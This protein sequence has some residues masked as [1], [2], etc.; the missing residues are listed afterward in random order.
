MGGAVSKAVSDV[1]DVVKKPVK[2]VA[3][4]VGIIPKSKPAA[5]TPAPAATAAATAPQPAQ[6]T[7]PAAAPAQPTPRQQEQIEQAAKRRSRRRG[8]ALLSEARLNPEEGVGQ[9]TLGTGPM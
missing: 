4:E 9:S 7:P 6:P 5:S 1:V 3:K 2:A 8:R